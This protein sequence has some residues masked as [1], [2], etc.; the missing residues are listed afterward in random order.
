MDNR[1]KYLEE[2]DDDALLAE[3]DNALAEIESYNEDLDDPSTGSSE[4][5]E[6][7]NDLRYEEEKLAAVEEIIRSRGLSVPSR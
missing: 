4:R 1:W 5:S 7:Y 6:I 3:R 2:L